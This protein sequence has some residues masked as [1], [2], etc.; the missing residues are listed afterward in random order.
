MYSISVI[1]SQRTSCFHVLMSAFASVDMS[2]DEL[3][4][5]FLAEQYSR[6]PVYEESKDNVIGIL[7]LKDLFF[8]RETHRN[9]AFDIYKV[10]R[11]P[12]FTYEYQKDFHLN[13]RDA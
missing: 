13:G 9:E 10:L 4:E 11:E 8:Y 1:L 2:Y 7:N 3:V 6:L 5:I 12:F